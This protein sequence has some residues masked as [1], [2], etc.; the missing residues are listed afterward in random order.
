[1]KVTLDTRLTIFDEADVV[2]GVILERLQNGNS[3]VGSQ[4]NVEKSYDSI[5]VLVAVYKNVLKVGN[6][7]ILPL[8]VQVAI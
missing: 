6:I 1:M 4:K 2:Y 3:H 8:D 5:L 7:V